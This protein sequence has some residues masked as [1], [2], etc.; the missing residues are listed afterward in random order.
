MEL[1]IRVMIQSFLYDHSAS[2]SSVYSTG[3][4]DD[5]V[6]SVADSSALASV[7]RPSP[8]R[9]PS[10]NPTKACHCLLLLFQHGF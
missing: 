5:L 9:A 6:F 10:K 7:T 2:V 3:I 4:S 1:E 8:T